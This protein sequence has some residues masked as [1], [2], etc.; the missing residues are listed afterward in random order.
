MNHNMHMNKLQPSQCDLWLTIRI[1]VSESQS[2]GFWYTENISNKSEP[3]QGALGISLIQFLFENWYSKYISVTQTPDHKLQ[4]MFSAAHWPKDSVPIG[5]CTHCFR[6]VS[7]WW[8]MD[9]TRI[10]QEMCKKC[11]CRNLMERLLGLHQ[12]ENSVKR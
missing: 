1:S 9:G 6:L 3:K 7:L 10:K 12:Q 4:N 2:F 8:L 5:T 11:E